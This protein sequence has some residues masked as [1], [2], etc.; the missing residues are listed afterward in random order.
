MNVVFLSFANSQQAPLPT[1]QKEDDAVFKSLAPRALKTTFPP[2]P[3]FHFTTID[4]ITEYV[5]LVPQ[6]HFCFS[7]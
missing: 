5:C 7:L 6:L 1:L 3:R 2:S 4:K